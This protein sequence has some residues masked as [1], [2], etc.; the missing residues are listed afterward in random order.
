MAVRSPFLPTLMDTPAPPEWGHPRT[1]RSKHATQGGQKS[2]RIVRWMF[3]FVADTTLAAM[4]VDCSSLSMRQR[5]PLARCWLP[6]SNQTTAANRVKRCIGD[7]RVQ[8]RHR[9]GVGSVARW[10]R[11]LCRDRYGQPVA[12]GV[13]CPAAPRLVRVGGAL[14]ATRGAFS[15]CSAGQNS[16][17]TAGPTVESIWTGGGGVGGGASHTVLTGGT[18]RGLLAAPPSRPHSACPRLAAGRV[19]EVVCGTSEDTYPYRGRRRSP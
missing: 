13:G 8:A 16:R 2:Y 15:K 18:P 17:A 1:R 14:L 12:S 4:A 5:S 3:W 10:S 7:Q 11:P 6:L 19:P 9:R